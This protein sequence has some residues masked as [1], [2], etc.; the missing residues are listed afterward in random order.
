MGQDHW[1]REEE[2][3][4]RL[5][6]EPSSGPCLPEQACSEKDKENLPQYPFICLLSLR[7][8]LLWG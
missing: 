3:E 6:Q 1:K 2:R 5:F 8:P 7:A 4:V